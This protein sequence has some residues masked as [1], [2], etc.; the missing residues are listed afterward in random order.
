MSYPG[1]SLLTE[2]RRPHPPLGRPAGWAGRSFPGVR[3][4]RPG[5][6]R[7]RP[8]AI[9]GRDNAGAADPAPGPRDR[10]GRHAG[11]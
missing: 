8:A 4:R 10:L 7:A 2:T 6:L 3:H 5:R 1:Q 9:R 11:I